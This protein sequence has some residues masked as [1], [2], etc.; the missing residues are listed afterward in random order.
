MIITVVADVLGAPNNG[1]TIAALNLIKA[2]TEKGHT[3][4]VVCPDKEKRGRQ[5]FYIVPTL[6]FGPLQPI[7]DHNG[8]ILAKGDAMTIG[9]A[10]HDADEVH[11]MLPFAV[12]RET[13]KI[14]NHMGIPVSAGFHAQAENL[15]AHFFNL[16]NNRTANHLIYLNFW[17]HFYR[18][19]DAI[20]YPTQFIREEFERAIGHPT[21]GY[22]I[23]NGVSSA[24]HHLSVARL[25]EFQG[26]F[27][28]LCTG[29]YSKEKEQS[30]L[31]KAVAASPHKDDLR[32]VFAGEGP[33]LKRLQKCAAKH[34]VEPLFRFFDR[35]ELVKIIN[36]CDLYVH[37]SS[38]EIEAI[39]CLE[40]LSC[41]LVPVINDSPNSATR[42]FALTP[43]NLFKMND[44]RDLAKKIDYWV[45]HP[46][47]KAKLALRYASYCGQF[48]FD[49]CMDQMEQMI[50]AT[51]KIDKKAET[52]S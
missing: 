36:M 3:V 12:G 38:I 28:I 49:R 11:I 10:L 25:P 23:S 31:I 15:T 41:G 48:D 47:E 30:L 39:G 40:A 7:V 21:K 43:N 35:D 2:L 45:E 18:Y 20:H 33:R 26:K 42:Y 46:E 1:T 4:R 51:S 14:A 19:V 16:M 50:V 9:R 27:V 22:V 24:F 34:Q 37:T 8:V 6:Q 29:R 52:R 13:V 17:N 5:G 44:Y 32:I